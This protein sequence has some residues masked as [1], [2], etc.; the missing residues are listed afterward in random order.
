ME[1]IRRKEASARGLTRY[2]TGKPCRRGH[3]SDRIVS[4]LTCCECKRERERSIYKADPEA[5]IA[6][7]KRWQQQ[8]RVRHNATAVRY[9]TER[10]KADPLH[11]FKSGMKSMISTA[12]RRRGFTKKSRTAQILGCDLEFFV[13]HIE[14]QFLKGMGW[15]NRSL[16]HIDHI[17]P[18]STA[19]NEEDVIAL[20]HVSNLR[21]MW[22]KANMTKKDQILFLI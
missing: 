7:T 8:N 12:L 14:R 20:N 16:W 5:A 11:A 4:T 2:F 3:V 18:L 1:I 9:Q 13:H 6:K 22:A 15:A 17:T 10:R 19:K 21:P